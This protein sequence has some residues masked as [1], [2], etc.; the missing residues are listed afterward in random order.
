[1]MSFLPTV[2]VG[3]CNRI[4]VSADLNGIF[5]SAMFLGMVTMMPPCIASADENTN[6]QFNTDYLVN[7]NGDP[8][9]LS[10]FERG[11]TLDSGEYK[12]SA[13]VNGKPV[14]TVTVKIDDDQA[15]FLTL[16]QIKQLGIDIDKIPT[17]DDKINALENQHQID[18]TRLVSGSKVEFDESNLRLNLSIPQAYLITSDSLGGDLPN[19][20]RGVNALF[21]DYNTNV[22]NTNAQQQTQFYAGLSTGANLAGWRLRHNGN[23][24]QS[25]GEDSQYTA[26]NTYAQRDIARLKSQLTLGEYYTPSELFDGVAY[27]GV[28]LAFDDRMLPDALRGY[29]PTVRG[30]AQTNAKVT[31]RQGGNILFETSVAPGPFAIDGLSGSGYAGDLAVT[32]TEADGRVRSFTVPFASVSQLL[33]PGV[34]R[35][36][37]ILGKYRDAR[38]SQTPAFLQAT[39]QQGL[40]SLLTSYT[41]AIAA[42]NYQ[43]LLGGF[44]VS[45][46]FGALAADM[47]HSVASDLPT[48][49]GEEKRYRGQSF[50]IG[51]SK[52]IESTQTNLTLAAYRFSSKGYLNLTDYAQFNDREVSNSLLTYRQRSRFQTNISQ[53]L[54]EGMGSFYL[55]GSVQNYWQGTKSND[56]NYQAGYT[57]GFRW[58]NL[59]VSISRT[60]TQYGENDTQ[61]Q[62]SVA[63]PLGNAVNSPFLTSSMTRS[64][65]GD[66]ASQAGLSGVAGKNNSLNYG[67]YGTRSQ[68][69]GNRQVSTGGNIQYSASHAAFTASVTKGEQYRQLGLGVSGSMLVH[70]GGVNFSQEQGE[71]K[72]IIEAKGAKGARLLNSNGA[73]VADNGYAIMSGLTPY[74][75]N[76]LSLDPKGIADDVELKVTE[77]TTIPGYGSV[78]VLS[79]PTVAGQPVLLK[80]QNDK[81]EPLPVGAEVID[82]TNNS[83]TLVGQG[84]RV[85]LR[86]QAPQGRVKVQW[87]KSVDRQCVADYS[88]PADAMDKKGP[89]LNVSAVCRRANTEGES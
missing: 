77:Q 53:T 48:T 50:R 17:N 74:R 28:Q 12:L 61:Y 78:V 1:M 24:S 58:G 14:D 47:T 84:S 42:E 79:Y 76:N 52:M 66:W 6:V 3:R 65:S 37:L 9:D 29:A 7:K 86:V 18:V 26:I 10:R 35:Y 63:I 5:R 54:G 25:S 64:Q 49:L 40:T 73:K 75:E 68:N 39:Y 13:Y 59:N 85:F 45:T 31:V 8:L 60:H 33:R 69:K 56:I 46:S 19:T 30:I 21:V 43:A 67:V 57:N 4:S 20:D 71:T 72:V 16:E 70:P 62:V 11:E 87:G 81:G 55:S 41:G 80:L 23:Y 15:L 34:H 51:Y 27:R 88:L 83:L 89:F 44:G 38:L 2:T 36:S 82:V 32:V 22:W